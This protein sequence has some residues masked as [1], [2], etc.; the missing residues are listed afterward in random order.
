[1]TFKKL[2]KEGL[3]H[4]QKMLILWNPIVNQAFK[5]T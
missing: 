2:Q 5:L 1:M 4:P 3:A